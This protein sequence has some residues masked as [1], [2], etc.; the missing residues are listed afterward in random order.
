MTNDTISTSHKT[1][2]MMNQNNDNEL[3]INNK[4]EIL[5]KL[6]SN[7]FDNKLL[8]LENNTENQMYSI[9]E[10]IKTSNQIVSTC[11]NLTWI[12]KPKL[13]EKRNNSINKINKISSISPAKI[14]LGR[15]NSIRPNTPFKK[16]RI[17]VSRL[18][19]ENSINRK[20]NNNSRKN[21]ISP[22]TLK[23]NTENKRNI[24]KKK[25]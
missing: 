12:I 22:F 8:L 6:L 21:E 18:T 11:I 14:T 5:K 23:K 2:M 19:T 1:E 9:Y 15:T 7:K 24:S 20:N 25:K 13:E 17:S 3:N 16:N 4:Y 10:G